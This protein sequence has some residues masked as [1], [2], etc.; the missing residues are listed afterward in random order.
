MWSGMKGISNDGNTHRP[1]MF[2]KALAD[3]NNSTC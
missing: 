1:K 3:T 2:I